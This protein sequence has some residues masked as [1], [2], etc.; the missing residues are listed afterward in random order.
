MRMTMIY[1]RVINSLSLIWALIS[2][3][4]GIIAYMFLNHNT[5]RNLQGVLFSDNYYFPKI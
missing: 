5:L 2:N 3:A 1:W 4:L